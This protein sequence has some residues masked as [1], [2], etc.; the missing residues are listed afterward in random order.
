M[1]GAEK[2]LWRHLR[3]RDRLSK[4]RVDGKLLKQTVQMDKI[5]VALGRQMAG[6][7]EHGNEPPGCIKYRK[8]D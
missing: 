7:C 4:Q 1:H 5:R 6:Y 3:E 2:K 8:F